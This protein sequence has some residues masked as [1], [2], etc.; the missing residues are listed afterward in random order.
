MCRAA[1]GGEDARPPAGRSALLGL[2]RQRRRA[3]THTHTPCTALPAR[4]APAAGNLHPSAGGRRRANF[5]I[6]SGRTSAGIK[7]SDPAGGAARIWPDAAP[8]A[9]T[10]SLTCSQGTISS[11]ALIILPRCW[12]FT[13]KCP[14]RSVTCCTSVSW[15]PVLDPEVLGPAPPHRHCLCPPEL[16]GH[17]P[18]FECPRF[19]FPIG[20]MGLLSGEIPIPLKLLGFC[21]RLLRPQHRIKHEIKYLHVL[22]N[23]EAIKKHI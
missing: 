2:L 4:S 14:P 10:P 21:L 20:F 22:S 23:Q 5:E 8:C 13:M 9:G 12:G 3:Q 1:L 16:E 19:K 11:R 17:R 15:G 6:A 7:R 18:V